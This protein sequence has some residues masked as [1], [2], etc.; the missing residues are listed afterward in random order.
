MADPIR[1]AIEGELSIFTASAVR[2]RLLDA[3]AAAGEVEADLSRV[4]EIDSAGLQLMLAAQ[5]EAVVQG[6]RLHI[7]DSSRPVLDIFELCGLAAVLSDSWRE[8][9]R[10]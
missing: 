2:D 6:K 1:V 3:F 8:G 5:K 9:G 7:A 10:E 4:T